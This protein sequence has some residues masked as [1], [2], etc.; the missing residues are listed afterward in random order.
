MF[1]AVSIRSRLILSFLVLLGLLLTVAAVSMQRLEGLTTTTQGIVN[2]RVRQAFLAQRFNQH[3]QAA[4]ISLLNL[5]QTGERDKRV[6]LYA[7]MDEAMAESDTAA[8]DLART[9]LTPTFRA[10][11]ERVADLRRGYANFLQ[12]TVE[13]IEIE[14]QALARRHFEDTTQKVLKTLLL[15]TQ[16]LEE[17]LQRTMQSELEQLRRAAANARQLVVLLSLSALLAGTVLAWTIARSIV[18]PVQEAVAVAQTIARGD[19][20]SAVP[21]GQRDEIGALLAALAIM[22]DRIASREARILRLAYV[23]PLTGLPNR[24]RFLE[25]LSARASTSLGALVILDIDRF[26]PINNALGHAVGDRLLCEVAERL[27]QAVGA[28]TVVA[29]LWGDQFALL[30]DGA[31]KSL[32]VHGV[33]QIR[34]A[35][36]APMIVDG[37]RLDIDASFGIALYPRDGS[38]ATVLMRRGDLAMTVAKRRH[39]SIAFG[40]ELDAEP[41]Q[42]Q[43]SLIGE[44]RDALTR[45]EFMV[46]YQPKLDLA[47]HRII[48]VEALI[49]WC[50][51][52]KGMIPPLQFIPFAEQ[53]GF[54]REITPW[55]LRQVIEHAAQ[56]QRRGVAVVASVNLSTLDLLNR[57][58]VTQIPRL[59][60]HFSLPPHQLCLEITESA[61]MDEPELAL[62]HLNELSAQGVKLSIDDYGSGQ[63]SLAY[64]KTLPVNEL[65]IDRVFITDIDTSPKNAAIV[66]STIL[67]CQELGLSVVAEGAET[68]QELA[69]LASNHCDV[70]QG[71]VVARPM[72]LKEFIDW[73]ENFNQAWRAPW[74]HDLGRASAATTPVA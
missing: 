66:R 8:S 24:T 12:E 3:A 48:G 23:D 7:A 61:L 44:M 19:Y 39:D 73:V 72:P 46:H 27:T 16:V 17:R 30:L 18:M 53:T 37:Q 64:V 34:A 47:L 56:W 52:G 38:N 6:P 42:E 67:L 14:G 25:L 36:R 57:D 9:G 71:Y 2:V 20:L 49:R 1:D 59:L 21:L 10:D 63:A 29:R 51:P 33:E 54:I 28:S 15:E 43:L 41:P 55:V 50:H 35:L 13:M 58:L 69:W 60:A 45:G 74:P 68:A 65:K 31:D 11:V 70:V 5:L 62:K 40:A 22:R 32:A 26:S 4:A